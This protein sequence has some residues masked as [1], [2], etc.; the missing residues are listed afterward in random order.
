[1]SKGGTC[2]DHDLMTSSV[3]GRTCRILA[4][5]AARSAS[6]AAGGPALRKPTKWSSTSKRRRPPA[7]L[8]VEPAP[9]GGGGRAA[10]A[11]S[12]L[13]RGAPTLRG[14]VALQ[15]AASYLNDAG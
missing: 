5:G 13:S 8:P 2:T 6:Y 12:A 14:G 1:M 4:C 11:R 7:A 9:R 15:V 3:S 10:A